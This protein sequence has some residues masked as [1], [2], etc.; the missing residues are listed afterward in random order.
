MTIA[1]VIKERVELLPPLSQQ[2]ALELIETLSQENAPATVRRDPY[3][4]L[5]DLKVD[6]SL[7]E[8]NTAR[9][10]AWGNFPRKFPK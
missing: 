10:E 6:I 9:R 2:K 3:G 5:A 7:E 8:F 1:E 4:S